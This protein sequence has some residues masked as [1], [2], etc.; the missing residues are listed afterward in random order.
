MS[1][2]R[3]KKDIPSVALPS[4]V[5]LPKINA[6][7]FRCS[8]CGNYNSLYTVPYD[9]KFKCDYCSHSIEI[10]KISEQYNGRGMSG[11]SGD[12][13]SIIPPSFGEMS[14]FAGVPFTPT[15]WLPVIPTITVFV[16]NKS[17]NPVEVTLWDKLPEDILVK[18]LCRRDSKI[19]RSYDDFISN[20]LNTTMLCRI[21]RLTDDDTL[22]EIYRDDIFEGKQ[23]YEGDFFE[24]TI[25]MDG[26]T[27]IKLNLA[28]KQTF[29]I[30]MTVTA[31]QIGN[32][33]Q[34]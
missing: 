33:A 8:G 13:I 14:G 28:P 17:E 5:K 21:N 11:F 32:F 12:G 3:K 24:S 22:E 6:I 25:V 30:L 31:R 10:E 4:I 18:V 20:M 1:L 9:G 29:S 16:R 19:L 23:K 34:A 26:K 2:F 27:F 15:V 7:T